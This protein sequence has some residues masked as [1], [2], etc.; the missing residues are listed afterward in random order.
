[1]STN[2]KI[3]FMSTNLKTDEKKKVPPNKLLGLNQ[4]LK[5]TSSVMV[6]NIE[7]ILKFAHKMWL[8]VL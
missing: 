5:L 3:K 2:L 6:D 8:I 7:S 4:E 1:M